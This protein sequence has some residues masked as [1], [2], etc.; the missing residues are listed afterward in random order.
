[1]QL[2][3]D[4]DDPDEETGTR[5]RTAERVAKQTGYPGRERQPVD[6]DHRA[7]HPQRALRPRR[8]RLDPV[9]RQPGAR[10]ARALQAAPRRG[11]RTLSALEI[12]DLVTVR[13]AMA[14][15][16]RLEMVRRIA[17]E[18]EGYVVELGT[19]GRLL[20]LQLEELMAGVDGERELV[21]RDYLV[22]A[23]ARRAAPSWTPS[24]TSTACRRPSCSTCRGRQGGRLPRGRRRARGR[25]Q[26]ARLPAAR[27]GAATAGRGGRPAGR[28]L[29]RP[30]EAAGRRHRRPAGRRRRR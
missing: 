12:E 10:H 16:Q 29:R 2:V 13:D 20:S 15:S 27:Q 19:D 22:S 24:P 23:A 1:V 14:V 5:H 8:Q 30:A 26:P 21:V 4:P 28:A 11:R 3:P 25:R 7:L 9:A 18:I 17:T 6:A